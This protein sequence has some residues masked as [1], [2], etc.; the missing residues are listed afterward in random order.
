V[1]LTNVNNFFGGIASIKKAK[2][3]FLSSEGE[4]E[5]DLSRID[6]DVLIRLK[7]I[8]L[9]LNVIGVI[10][11]AIFLFVGFYYKLLSS[12]CILI[13][14]VI[15]CLYFKFNNNRTQREDNQILY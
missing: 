14:L 12:I 2:K 5:S 13:P 8:Y 4:N 11:P 15:L 9:V 3:S 1:D 6:K 7:K 10:A